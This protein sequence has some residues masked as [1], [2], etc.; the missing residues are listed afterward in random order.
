MMPRIK[1][2]NLKSTEK[3][4]DLTGRVRALKPGEEADTYFFPTNS[5]LEV[6]D[7]EPIW[8]AVVRRDTIDFDAGVN[9]TT[10][11]V[12]PETDYIYILKIT[13]NV[14]VWRQDK[15]ITPPEYENQTEDHPI[16]KIHGLKLMNK[17]YL[18]GEGTCEVVQYRDIDRVVVQGK[19]VSSTGVSI[20]DM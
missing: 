11:T 3:Y 12:Y 6:L 13:G 18:E 17:I 19:G 2:N 15:T 7:D 9:H 10:L 1:N 14:S 8:N 4:I 16:V 20:G 5:N